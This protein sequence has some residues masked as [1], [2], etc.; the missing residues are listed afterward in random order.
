MVRAEDGKVLASGL[1]SCGANSPVLHKG[2]VYYVRG[3]AN[4][5]RL[6]KSVTE[7]IKVQALW[8][9]NVKGGGYWFSSPVVHKGLFYAANDQGILTVLDAATGK[10]VYEER[11]N[12]GG[13][14]YPSI[15]LASN[16]IYVS[17]DSG[18]TVVLEPRRE[19]KELAR[20][21]L[22]PFRSSLVF[23]GKRVYVRTAK[24]LYCIGE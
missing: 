11:L 9:G 24:H 8:K 22:E 18:T 13:T 14:T 20:N 12:L 23:D 3:A 5:F 7:P 2:I 6:P 21:K 4:A 1:G 19:Y 10:R 15:S 16:R 17:S